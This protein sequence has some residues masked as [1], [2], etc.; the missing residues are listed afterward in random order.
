MDL[1]TDVLD[2][3][4]IEANALTLVLGPVRVSDVV[5]EVFGLLSAKAELRQV[6]LSCDLADQVVS[7]DRRRLRQVLLNLVGNSIRHGKVGGHVEVRSG[8]AS[9]EAVLC[10]VVEDDGPGI[11]PEL[12]PRI[13]T[14]FARAIPTSA[15][16]P[17][18]SPGHEESVGLG[19]GLA[20]G[21]MHAMAGELSIGCSATTGTSMVLRIPRAEMSDL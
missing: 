9:D 12:L 1:L 15:P 3:S 13:F 18:D 19:L 4:R 20:H 17:S 7:A 8:P 5:G 2:F 6:Q 21:L 16:S 14:P 11:P 10:V